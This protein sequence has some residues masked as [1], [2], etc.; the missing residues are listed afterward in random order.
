[1]IDRGECIM[2]VTGV[3]PFLTRP[4][5]KVT[6]GQLNQAD[7]VPAKLRLLAS[8]LVLG[9]LD[10]DAMPDD[11]VDYDGFLDAF[12]MPPDEDQLAAVIGNFPPADH[13]DAGAYLACAG[14]SW[15]YLQ[16]RYPVAPERQLLGSVQR[17]PSEMALT[18]FEF[19]LLIVDKPLGVFGLVDSGALL[20]PQAR[21]LASCYPTLHAAIV[22]AIGDRIAAEQARAPSYEPPFSL[23]LSTLSGSPHID[24]TVTR[25]LAAASAYKQQAAQQARA[26]QPQESRMAN[27]LSPPSARADK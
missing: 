10:A 14:R 17:P 1:M 18:Q 8:K 19:E 9:T 22:D 15:A 2:A 4:P 20:A 16:G 3:R 25:G 11:A 26:Q 5:G 6:T 12:T 13:D 21:A 23:A 7:D 27:M 24:P